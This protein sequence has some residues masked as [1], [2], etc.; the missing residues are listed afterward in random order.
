MMKKRMRTQGLNLSLF[1]HNAFKHI[2]CLWSAVP[3]LEKLSCS[4]II[5]VGEAS[6][7]ALSLI[8]QTVSFSLPI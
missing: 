6:V 7:D 5:C 4:E 2:L 1:K 8:P 3:S